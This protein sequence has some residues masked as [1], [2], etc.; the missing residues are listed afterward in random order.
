MKASELK[1][2]VI[3]SVRINGDNL[4]VIENIYGSIQKAVDELVDKH[5]SVNVTD[6]HLNDID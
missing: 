4:E 5:L 3:K 2:D 6:N 1:K